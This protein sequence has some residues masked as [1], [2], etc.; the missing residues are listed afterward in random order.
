MSIPIRIQFIVF[1]GYIFGLMM[2]FGVASYPSEKDF[3]ILMGIFSTALPLEK[4][5][6]PIRE[7]FCVSYGYWFEVNPFLYA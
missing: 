4:K 1:Y 5:K 3:R 2:P 6:V 7:K